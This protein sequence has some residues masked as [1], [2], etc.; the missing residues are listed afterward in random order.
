MTQAAK[1][2]PTRYQVLQV[3]DSH[4]QGLYDAGWAYVEPAEVPGYSIIA[5]QSDKPPVVPLSFAK[6]PATEAGHVG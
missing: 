5:W 3:H 4:L 2:V 6:V 1:T